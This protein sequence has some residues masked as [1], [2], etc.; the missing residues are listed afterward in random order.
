MNITHN[1]NFTHAT[2]LPKTLNSCNMR[3][4]RD[5]FFIFSLASVEVHD[6]LRTCPQRAALLEPKVMEEENQMEQLFVATLPPNAAPRAVKYLVLL[7]SP[8]NCIRDQS[9]ELEPKLLGVP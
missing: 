4:E 5:I 1:S 2:P 7:V 3:I 8:R 9:L 6:I